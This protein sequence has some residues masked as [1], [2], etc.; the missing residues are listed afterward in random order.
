MF[1]KFHLNVFFCVRLIDLVYMA[2]PNAYTLTTG[3]L[4]KSDWCSFFFSMLIK[5]LEL[6]YYN[7]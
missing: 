5:D 2:Y 1:R 4:M 6:L 3:M 7:Y